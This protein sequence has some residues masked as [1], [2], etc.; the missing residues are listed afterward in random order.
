MALVVVVFSI[1][2]HLF[3]RLL[4]AYRPLRLCDGTLTH[5]AVNQPLHLLDQDW[6]PSSLFK[7]VRRLRDAFQ[8]DSM[9]IGLGLVVNLRSDENVPQ[10]MIEELLGCFDSIVLS[11][12]VSGSIVSVSV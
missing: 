1:S 4:S 3:Y 11:G 8:D 7:A 9:H 12:T 2:R 10:S 6:V 5:F